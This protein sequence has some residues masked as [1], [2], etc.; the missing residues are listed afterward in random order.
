M[1]TWWEEENW[2]AKS[3][4]YRGGNKNVRE[5]GNKNLCSNK[6]EI[7]KYKNSVEKRK[8]VELKQI[9]QTEDVIKNNSRRKEGK[10]KLIR[11]ARMVF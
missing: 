4:I 8:A 3:K 1:Q 7:A 2:K 5:L 11:I 9:K 10:K 6:Q